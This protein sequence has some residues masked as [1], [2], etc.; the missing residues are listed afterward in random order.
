M[1]PAQ[2]GSGFQLWFLP[3]LAYAPAPPSPVPSTTPTPG[4]PVISPTASPTPPVVI[5][6]IQIT[7]YVGLDAT[8]PMAWI[9]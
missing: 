5:K 6:P 2:L 1:A 7:T 8:S 9:N 3:K 4:A